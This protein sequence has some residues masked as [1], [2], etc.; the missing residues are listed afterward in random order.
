M[1]GSRV[2]APMNITV[3]HG[4][5]PGNI[6]DNDNSLP[7]IKNVQNVQYVNQYTIQISI[8]NINIDINLQKVYCIHWHRIQVHNTSPQ[9]LQNKFRLF[10]VNLLFVISLTK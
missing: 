9:T 7:M 2:G 10:F 4:E 3:N 1:E 5:I 6:C 8:Y